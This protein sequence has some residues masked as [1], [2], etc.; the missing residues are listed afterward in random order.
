MRMAAPPAA[1][2]KKLAYTICAPQQ[3][4]IITIIPAVASPRTMARAET[5]TT[6]RIVARNAV[7][8]KA[9]I[10]CA[11]LHGCV[12]QSVQSLATARKTTIAAGATAS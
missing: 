4:R 10:F 7:L 6:P 8:E 2:A 3:T 11:K 5:A 1:A 9:S 12:L